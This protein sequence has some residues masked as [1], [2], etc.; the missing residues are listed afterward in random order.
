MSLESWY[1]SDLRSR[2]RYHAVSLIVS[3]LG[4]VIVE[5]GKASIRGFSAVSKDKCVNLQVNS[6][7]HW[8][9]FW[10]SVLIKYKLWHRIHLSN[11][12]SK[13]CPISWSR[14][15]FVFLIRLFHSLY[16][17]V[18]LL[19]WFVLN[20][21]PIRGKHLFMSFQKSTSS[22]QFTISSRFDFSQL[23]IFDH[24]VENFQSK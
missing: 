16:G 11:I 18:L 24:G 8:L 22:V 4:G 21:L 13:G 10:E 6:S 2:Y 5:I 1:R 14:D 19:S 15:N 12:M 9:S 20:L 23:P 3:K 7:K 17:T